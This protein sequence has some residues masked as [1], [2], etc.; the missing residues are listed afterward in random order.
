MSKRYA[1]D[2][3]FQVWAYHSFPFPKRVKEMSLSRPNASVW[4]I[5]RATRSRLMQVGVNPLIADMQTLFCIASNS[6]LFTVLAM[7]QLIEHGIELVSGGKL[8]WDTKII[9]IMPE[10]QTVD[11]F[12][13]QRAT[14][15]DAASEPCSLSGSDIADR[16]YASRYAN[17]QCCDQVRRR[18]ESSFL[19]ILRTQEPSYVLDFYKHAPV[20]REFR[21]AMQSNNHAY[22][23]LHY[24]FDLLSPAEPLTKWI[25]DRILA[26][27]GM[28]DTY[29][30]H[31]QAGSTGRRSEGFFRQFLDTEGLAE[32]WKSAY[33]PPTSH[34][35]TLKSLGWMRK[36]GDAA[37]DQAA[38]GGVVTSPVDL[39]RISSRTDQGHT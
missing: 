18:D 30:N 14:L 22:V 11:D 17:S 13:T 4:P 7:G 24:I 2:G 26:P 32:H 21:T 39:V 27:L 28:A 34:L 12:S 20:T 3:T 36:D 1:S 5:P 6:K 33:S 29:Y 15:E 38:W 25:E 23:L 19:L 35:G 8:A 9:D 37:L 10:W 16:R 31:V